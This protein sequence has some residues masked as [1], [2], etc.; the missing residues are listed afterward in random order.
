MKFNQNCLAHLDIDRTSLLNLLREE[1]LSLKSTLSHQ[2]YC[3][4]FS[5][6]PLVA[7][8]PVDSQLASLGSL[9]LG[10]SQDEEVFVPT[11]FSA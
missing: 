6:F 1:A 8:D 10:S 7:S 4:C 2:V 5:K 11:L 3:Q 9:L